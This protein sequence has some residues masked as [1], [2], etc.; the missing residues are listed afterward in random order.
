MTLV[1]DFLSTSLTPDYPKE[2]AV[3]Y[4]DPEKML[5]FALGLTP[6]VTLIHD[7][8]PIPQKEFMLVLHR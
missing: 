1:V 6:N 5:S 3:F 2:D 8:P 4:H 7:Y